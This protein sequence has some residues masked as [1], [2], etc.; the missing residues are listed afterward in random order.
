M[1]GHVVVDRLRKQ[2][3]AGLAW[4]TRSGAAG[5]IP[6]DALDGRRKIRAVL[7]RHGPFTWIINC[8]AV[9][10]SLIDDTDGAS[11]RRAEQVNGEF[12]HQLAAAAAETGARVIHISTDAVFPATATRCG[13]GT[14]PAPD[15]IYGR[16]KLRGEV[17]SGS[18]LNL[19]CSIVGFDPAHGRGLLEWLRRQRAGARVPGFTD[20]LW[21]G[22]TTLQL[23]E[24]CQR[25]IGGLFD[26]ARAEGP[27]HHFCP[28]EPVSKCELASS[29]ARV[30]ELPLE[31]VPEPSGR[32]IS[33][34]LDTDYRSISSVFQKNGRLE[35]ALA[36]LVFFRE[37]KKNEKAT[38]DY[39]GHPARCYS[40]QPGLEQNPQPQ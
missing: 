9:L 10:Q 38:G 23:A 27:T 31:V 20:Q 19:R 39:P 17:S 28:L 29:L 40:G 33:R 34:R 1:L 15:T 26:T 25:L 12:P 22:C 5:G 16:S 3:G 36:R 32:P 8:V 35:P 30:L 11:L 4:T 37:E 6:F 21:V 7:D 24:L 14:A 13:E 18:V 2:G